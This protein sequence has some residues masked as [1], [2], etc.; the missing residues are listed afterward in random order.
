MINDALKN[1]LTARETE[2]LSL[3]VQER[4]SAEIASL[5][6]LS[7]RTVDTH[8]KNMI[9]KTGSTTLIGMV[10][11][12]IRLGL[13]EGYYFKKKSKQKQKTNHIRNATDT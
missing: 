3:I 12:A 8:R 11:F 6:H 2:I 5:L 13:L 10:K 1:K 4:T 9:R 7:I